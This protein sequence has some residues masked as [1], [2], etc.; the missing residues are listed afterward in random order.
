MFHKCSQQYLHIESKYGYFKLSKS[1]L[2]RLQEPQIRGKKSFFI[3]DEFGHPFYVREK[4][5]ETIEDPTST[6]SR[7]P[8]P[9]TGGSGYNK[10][11]K[12]YSIFTPKVGVEKWVKGTEP[13]HWFGA[14]DSDIHTF[15][16][17]VCSTTSEITSLGAKGWL[18][19]RRGRWNTLD[20]NMSLEEK[21]MHDEGF[22]ESLELD[23][24]PGEIEHF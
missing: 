5:R 19:R 3:S 8:N 11:E 12:E 4:I 17:T 18:V 1:L 9:F 14:F 15:I 10:Y 2:D 16:V 22:S 23:L 24:E 21:Y 13:A 6:Y 20:V 7:S